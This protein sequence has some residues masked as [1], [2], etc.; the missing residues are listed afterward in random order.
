MKIVLYL[1]TVIALLTALSS[2]TKK[3][4]C[5]ISGACN[6]DAAAEKNDG[7][8]EYEKTWF[9][10][11]DGDGMGNPEVSITDCNQPLDYVDNADGTSGA[12]AVNFT[13]LDCDGVSHD[14]FQELDDNVIVVM[15][16][17]MPCTTCISDPL[18]AINFVDE[19]ATSHP[20]RVVFYL[21]DDYANTTCPNLA[22]WADFYGLGNAKKFSDTSIK[23][24]DYGVDGM[25][26]I[27]V[28]GGAN[29]Q[30]YFNKNSSAE[31]VKEAIEKA[32][33]D[34]P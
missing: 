20:G 5:N 4:G 11:L 29:H 17:V 31:G 30:V 9:Q 25:P 22:G 13:A 2:C 10:D 23:M 34:N 21:V 6:F 24:S 19:F 14:L 1:V 28:L 16:W 8:C 12:P 27:V 32:L 33:S 18:E 15:A 26:K 7:S 3:R